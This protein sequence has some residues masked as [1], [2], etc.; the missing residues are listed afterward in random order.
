MRKLLVAVMVIVCAITGLAR[1]FT[2]EDVIYTVLDEKA[3]TVETKA[4]YKLE[5]GEDNYYI[6]GNHPTT[7]LLWLTSTVY[8][9]D[10]EYTLTRIGDFSFCENEAITLAVIPESVEEIGNYAFL[11]CNNLYGLNTP[12]EYTIGEY[13]FYGCTRLSVITLPKNLEKINT[14]AFA[15]CLNLKDI[16]IPSSVTEI[17]VAA[18]MG[19]GI[20]QI[21]LPN[22]VTTID[23]LAFAYTTKM[24]TLYLPSNLSAK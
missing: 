13:S 11:K 23:R 17:G 10:T 21:T 15:L 4:G 20:E 1:D 8:D 24:K 5:I 12:E 18:F 19:T 9:G 22:N 6:P 16:E 3:K 2:Y 14:G 7:A